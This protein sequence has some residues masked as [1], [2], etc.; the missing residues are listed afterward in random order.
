MF[1]ILLL[2]NLKP[3]KNNIQNAH[4]EVYTGKLISPEQLTNDTHSA[5]TQQCAECTIHTKEIKNECLVLTVANSVNR[6]VIKCSFTQS[7]VLL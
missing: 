5:Q 4:K 2:N 6:S 7:P 1:S 3:Y